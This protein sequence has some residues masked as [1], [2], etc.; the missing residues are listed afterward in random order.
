MARR[1]HK[2][3]TFYQKKQKMNIALI[4]EVFNW[5]FWIFAS[6]LIAFVVVLCV[7]MQ[8]SMIGVSMETSLYN[9]QEVLVN[10]FI[11]KISS[12][13]RGDVIVFLPNGNQNAHYYI[14]RVVA[15][16]GETVQIRDGRVYVDGAVLEDGRTYDKIADAGIAED[17]MS[18]ARMS[19]LYWEIIE[20]TVKTAVPATLELS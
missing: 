10:R 17:A 15:V 14:K 7:G 18:L 4:K 8:T 6:V 5:I 9:G 20:I 13:R 19:T 2:G 1:R 16:P 11:Y 12:P 3:L